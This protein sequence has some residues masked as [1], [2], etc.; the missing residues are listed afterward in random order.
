[1]DGTKPTVDRLTAAVRTNITET[2][3]T[4]ANDKD[5]AD[6]VR[7]DVVW[8]PESVSDPRHYVGI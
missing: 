2:I 6:R 7:V 3:D 4:R 8:N 5:T 1:M